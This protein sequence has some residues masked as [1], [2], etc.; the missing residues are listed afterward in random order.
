MIEYIKGNIFDTK[1]EYIVNPVNTVGIMGAGLALQF[2][3]KYPYMFKKYCEFCKDKLFDKEKIV[4]TPCSKQNLENKTIILF[5]TKNHWKYS[6]SLILIEQGLDKLLEKLKNDNK[7][8]TI[9]FP[10]LGCGCGG[11]TWEVDVKPLMEKYLKNC[12]YI[13]ALIYI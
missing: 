11:L 9:A 1:A 13:N 5:P 8:Y 4:F 7:V 12:D 6:S 10:K 2:K 3:L